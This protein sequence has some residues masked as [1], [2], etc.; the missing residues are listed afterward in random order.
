MHGR[1][2]VMFGMRRCAANQGAN[3]MPHP[4]EDGLTGRAPRQAQL[5]AAHPIDFIARHW[6]LWRLLDD[7]L[8]M[9]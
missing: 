5:C 9:A 8:A 1:Y 2:G 6:G 4:Y 3:A 7:C